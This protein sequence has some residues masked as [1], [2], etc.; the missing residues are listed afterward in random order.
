MTKVADRTK[1]KTIEDES[2]L[3]DPADLQVEVDNA[4]KAVEDGKAFFRP[5]GTENV[6]RLYTEAKT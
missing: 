6:L 1:F 5:S 3:T 4:V 2:R